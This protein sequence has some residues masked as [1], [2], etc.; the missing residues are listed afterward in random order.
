MPAVLTRPADQ[1]VEIS[2]LAM[3]PL[4]PKSVRALILMMAGLPRERAGEGLASFSGD[5]R[6]RIWSAADTLA[7]DAGVIAQCA[8]TAPLVTH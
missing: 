3:W 5:E 1:R 2:R 6:R 7:R 4:T 8:H